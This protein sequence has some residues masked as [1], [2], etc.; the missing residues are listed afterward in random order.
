MKTLVDAGYSCNPYSGGWT[1]IVE[2]VY[3]SILRIHGGEA[4]ISLWEKGLQV[5]M[6]WCQSVAKAIEAGEAFLAERTA[7]RKADRPAPD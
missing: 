5:K 2:E 6:E 4:R 3:L 1:K 7:E